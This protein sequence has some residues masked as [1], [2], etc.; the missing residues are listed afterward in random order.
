VYQRT[1]KI[2]KGINNVIEFDIKNADQKRIDLSTL[3]AMKLNVMD[4]AGNALPFSP[5][6]VSA[7][8][9]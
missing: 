5:Y 9:I 6:S 8:A 7:T 3:T 4:A 2:Y 1:L